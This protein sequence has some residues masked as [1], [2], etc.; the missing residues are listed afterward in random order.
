MYD[1]ALCQCL[2][3]TSFGPSKFQTFLFGTILLFFSPPSLSRA[4]SEFGT[5]QIPDFHCFPEV[6]GGKQGSG[7]LSALCQWSFIAKGEV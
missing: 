4:L 7:P 6:R 5:L 3:T 1:Q 2:H